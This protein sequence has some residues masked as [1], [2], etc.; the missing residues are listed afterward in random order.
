MLD[1]RLINKSIAAIL[2]FLPALAGAQGI[3]LIK[4]KK[5]IPFPT[6]HASPA[7]IG[8]YTDKD[9]LAYIDGRFQGWEVTWA[10]LDSFQVRRRV[11][12]VDSVVLR[13]TPRYPEGYQY[14]KD[15]KKDGVKYTLLT[16]VL[17]YEYR[18]F[19]FNDTRKIKYVTYSGN[20][21]GCMGCLLIPVFNVGFIIWAIKRW[22]AKELELERYSR[23][24]R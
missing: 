13:K 4:G 1:F 12:S 15:F 24:P 23:E 17:E 22:D 8:V 6:I 7:N 3:Y 18:V 16:K 10:T 19:A 2:L 9:T 5:R 11:S 20:G 14:N 21:S